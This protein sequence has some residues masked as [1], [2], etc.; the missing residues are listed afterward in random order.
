M[1]AD[2]KLFLARSANFFLLHLFL[3]SQGYNNAL[4]I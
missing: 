1:E 2:K 3:G 4:E